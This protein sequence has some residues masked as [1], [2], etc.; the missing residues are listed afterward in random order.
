MAGSPSSIV[1]GGFGNGSFAGS[2]SLIIEFG[3]GA[4]SPPSSGSVSQLLGSVGVNIG[5]GLAG[6]RLYIGQDNV[7][8]WGSLEIPSS[9]LYDAVTGSYVN[10]ATITFQLYESDGE[11]T[12]S[13]GSGSC[14]YVADSQGLYRGVLEDGVSLT[15]GV[16]YFMEW[17]ATCSGGR[18]G[19]RRVSYVAGYQGS[20]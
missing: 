10:D 18:V 12:V 15:S 1:M 16:S 14:S 11:T 7:V 3:F 8:Y 2:P 19:R 9:G 5:T 13:D 17:L 6:G 20:R 4:G